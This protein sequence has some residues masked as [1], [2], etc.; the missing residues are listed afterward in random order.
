TGTNTA[1]DS[2]MTQGLLFYLGANDGLDDGEHDGFSGNNNTDGAINGP[3]DGGAMMLSVTPQNAGNAPTASNPE[4]IANY[5]LRACAD[6]ICFG[7]TTQQQ[8]VYQGCDANTP[9]NNVANDQCAPGT[10]QN[11]NVY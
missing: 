6:G 2:I 10:A 7:V 5:S 11:D 3:S 9:Q 1:L 8:T 4:G